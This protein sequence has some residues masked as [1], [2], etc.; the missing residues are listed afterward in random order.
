MHRKSAKS[1][2]AAYLKKENVF[3]KAQARPVKAGVVAQLAAAMKKKKISKAEMAVALKTSRSQ[4]DR[5]LDP[6]RD[7]TLS[8]LRRAAALVGR[9]VVIELV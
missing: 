7:V 9:R 8:S 5:I 1:R 6:A 2:V 4:V 3:K